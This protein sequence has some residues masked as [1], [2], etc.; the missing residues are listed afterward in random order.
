MQEEVLS[1][2]SKGRIHVSKK[3]RERLGVKK[4]VKVRLGDGKMVIEPSIDPLD[5]LASEV[6]FTFT[7]VV[8]ELP[9][10][11]RAAEKQLIKEAK[12]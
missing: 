12:G 9:S 11:R 4:F 10:L 2:D 7:S 1:V 5:E 3:L 8:K 6:E